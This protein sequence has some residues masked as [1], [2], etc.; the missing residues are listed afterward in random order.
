MNLFEDIYKLLWLGRCGESGVKIDDEME[1]L[2]GQ[3]VKNHFTQ[4]C[5]AVSIDLSRTDVSIVDYAV[6]FVIYNDTTKQI[7]YLQQD[8][9]DFTCV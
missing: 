8:S 2:L 3:I 7:L 6:C 5:G 9:I 1:A 4:V